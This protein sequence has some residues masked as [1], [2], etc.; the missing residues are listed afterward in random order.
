VGYLTCSA[1]PAPLGGDIMADTTVTISGN[2]TGDPEL[3]FT[4]NGVPVAAF[5]VAVTPRIKDGDNWRDGDT[6]FFRCNAW[7]ELGEN[8]AESFQKGDRVIVSGTL[9]QR[10]WEA[11]DGTKRSVVEITADDAGPSLRWATAEPHKTHGG[12][13]SRQR[14]ENPSQ[15]EKP[16][17]ERRPTRRA[18]SRSS[19]TQRRTRETVPS[20]GGDFDEDA[21]F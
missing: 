3:R 16:K 20:T 14:A 1:S 12:N 11:D 10:S 4:G 21:P 9:K 17:Q 18:S 5:S 19:S 15:E 13:S 6:S 2:L 7:R 8:I